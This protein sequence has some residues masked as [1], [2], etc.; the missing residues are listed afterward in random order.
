MEI[1]A[2]GTEQICSHEDNIGFN[3]EQRQ[4]VCKQKSICW[5]ESI[6][7]DFIL[8]QIVYISKS[9]HNFVG[10]EDVIEVD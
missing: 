3:Y 7:K 5:M 4:S 10:L 2:I 6:G 1:D 9:W 8:H